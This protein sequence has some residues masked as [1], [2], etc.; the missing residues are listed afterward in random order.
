MKLFMSKKSS[1]CDMKLPYLNSNNLHK[2][3]QC[4]QMHWQSDYLYAYM[5]RLFT[6]DNMTETPQLNRTN[7]VNTKQKWKLKNFQFGPR[8]CFSGPLRFIERCATGDLRNDAIITTGIRKGC[9]L[10][11]NNFL[12]IFIRLHLPQ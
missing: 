3:P 10:T 1:L 4:Y 9:L 5:S 2:T 6:I 11:A 8:V 7:R 12:A